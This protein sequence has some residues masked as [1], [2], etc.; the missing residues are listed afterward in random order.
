MSGYL[1]NE[2]LSLILDD[3]RSKVNLVVEDEETARKLFLSQKEK[4]STKQFASDKKKL[5]ADK[6][7]VTELDGLMQSIY[8]DK[9]SGKVAESVCIK[10]LEKYEAEQNTLIDE[11]SELEERINAVSQDENDVDEFIRRLKKYTDIQELTREIILELIE[12]ITVDKYTEE[13]PREIHIYYK[14]LDKPLNSK[15]ALYITEN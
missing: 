14:L 10:L 8:E 7:R 9:V 2:M 1:E 11:V 3:I 13:K 5:R 15:K 6:K 12:Y 4:I